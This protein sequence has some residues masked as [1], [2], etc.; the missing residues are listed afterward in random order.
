M[1]AYECQLNSALRALIF[2]PSGLTTNPK[3]PG[4]QAMATFKALRIDKAD[5]G[6]IAAITQFDEAEFNTLTPDADVTEAVQWST[7]NYKDGLAVT[8][9]SPLV[10]RFPMIAG[11]DF[12]DAVVQSS[13][14]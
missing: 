14:P 7:L 2:P 10:R 3:N 8:G 11:T 13:N 4:R 12:A 6:T 9:K 5:K 1:A